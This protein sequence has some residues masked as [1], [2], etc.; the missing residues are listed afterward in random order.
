MHG[1]SRANQMGA[2]G[3]TGNLKRESQ[4]GKQMPIMD[5]EGI[6]GRSLN[7]VKSFSSASKLKFLLSGHCNFES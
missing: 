5:Y 7:M 4:K 6:L 3:V 1:I 2:S